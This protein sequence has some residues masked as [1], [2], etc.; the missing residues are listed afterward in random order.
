MGERSPGSTKRRWVP[1]GGEKK[2]REKIHRE[3]KFADDHK[4]LPFT[5]SKPTKN[6]KHDLF[7]CVECGTIISA[8]T[9][10]IMCVCS[11]CSKATKVER[12]KE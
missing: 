6:K 2:L 3:S 5:F 11:C 10:T 4:D 1:E 8:P 9:N 7:E 12:I